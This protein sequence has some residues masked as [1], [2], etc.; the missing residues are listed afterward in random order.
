MKKLILV[1][2]IVFCAVGASAEKLTEV[3]DYSEVHDDVLFGV[4]FDCKPPRSNGMTRQTM[5]VEH[6]FSHLDLETFYVDGSKFVQVYEK[7][8]IHCYVSWWTT[9]KYGITTRER[10][11]LPESCDVM[12]Q[13]YK[14]FLE[15][16]GL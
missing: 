3:C 16:Y 2:A 5:Y 14:Q 10:D 9:D 15:R 12:I 1:L 6:D 7:N 8:I 11:R 4:S 13:K